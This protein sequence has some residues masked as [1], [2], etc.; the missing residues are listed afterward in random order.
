M[1]SED[2]A[3]RFRLEVLR[4]GRRIRQEKVAES[5]TDAQLDVAVHLHDAGPATPGRLAEIEGVSPPA[6]NRTVNALESAGFARRTADANDGRRVSV[7]LT[8]EGHAL[9]EETRRR[10]N[11]RMKAEFMALAPRDRAVLERATQLMAE[12]LRR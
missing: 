9:V 4:L 8:A 5:V 1:E 7:E 6:M 10:R 2:A 3:T 11:A 12:L